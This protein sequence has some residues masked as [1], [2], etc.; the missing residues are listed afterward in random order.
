MDD[1]SDDDDHAES[2]RSDTDARK[3]APPTGA[4]LKSSRTGSVAAALRSTS[5]TNPPTSESLWVMSPIR[6]RTS[7]T[8]PLAAVKAALLV[9]AETWLQKKR[10]KKRTRELARA[11]SSAEKLATLG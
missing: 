2:L 5:A 11:A 7:F 3:A 9:P 8:L 1:D 4:E 6:Q 10:E